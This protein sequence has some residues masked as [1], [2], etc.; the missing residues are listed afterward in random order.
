MSK[1][2]STKLFRKKANKNTVKNSYTKCYNVKNKKMRN[3]VKNRE[4]ET[5]SAQENM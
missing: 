3:H 2:G 5:T 1:L 4:R